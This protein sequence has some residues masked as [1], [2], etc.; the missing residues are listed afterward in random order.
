MERK[1]GRRSS[2]PFDPSPRRGFVEK[3]NLLEGS[4]LPLNSPSGERRGKKRTSAQPTPIPR[5]DPSGEHQRKRVGSGT[6]FPLLPFGEVALRGSPQRRA[7][8]SMRIKGPRTLQWS[9]HVPPPCLHG[10]LTDPSGSECD[11]R[12]VKGDL[13]TKP[14]G[15]VSG[16]ETCSVRG[17]RTLVHSLLLE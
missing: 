15:I 10:T 9:F 2:V 4:S 16:C 17:V 7:C 5:W 14:S 12:C 6:R 8:P 3:A 11:I 13:G 1:D